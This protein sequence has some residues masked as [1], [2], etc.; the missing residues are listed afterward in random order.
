VQED[1]ERAVEAHHSAGAG[2]RAFTSHA[3]SALEG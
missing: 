3:S 2:A 1:V